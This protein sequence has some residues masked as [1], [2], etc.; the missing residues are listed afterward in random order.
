MTIEGI[1]NLKRC[2]VRV[3]IRVVIHRETYKRLPELA[4]F[5]ARN[6]GATC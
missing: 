5:I 2:G 4:R 1:L 3:E 6:L